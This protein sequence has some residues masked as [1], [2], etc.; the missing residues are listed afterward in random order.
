MTLHLGL[1]FGP[2]QLRC[3]LRSV[4][5]APTLQEMVAC[6]VMHNHVLDREYTFGQSYKDFCT[7]DQWFNIVSRDVVYMLSFKQT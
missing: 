5:V 3:A 7:C 4:S 2:L 1:T 6:H